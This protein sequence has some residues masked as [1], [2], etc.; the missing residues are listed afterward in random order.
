MKEIA[1]IFKNPQFDT[2]IILTK[3]D[4]TTVTIQTVTLTFCFVIFFP[5]L[6][7][8]LCYVHRKP[9]MSI[10]AT[11]TSRT[12]LLPSPNVPSFSCSPEPSPSGAQ[13]PTTRVETVELMEVGRCVDGTEER[14]QT[15]GAVPENSADKPYTIQPATSETLSTEMNQDGM[16]ETGLMGKSV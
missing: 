12:V 15:T 2:V 8:L 4:F 9:T 16:L 7:M 14:P 13:T 5:A 1:T 10:T 3:G 6:P 11:S